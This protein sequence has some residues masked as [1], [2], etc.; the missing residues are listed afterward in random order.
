MNYD[1]INHSCQV[2]SDDKNGIVGE[3]ID[4][5]LK[6]VCE[7][8]IKAEITV[9]EFESVRI[10]GQVKDSCGCPM[11]RT[12]LKLLRCD[13]ENFSGIAHTISDCQGFYQFDLCKKTEGGKYRIIAG[14]VSECGEMCE[15]K[16]LA[17]PLFVQ[18]GKQV[19]D[20]RV[21]KSTDYTC[22]SGENC[23]W[24]ENGYVEDYHCQC[25]KCLLCKTCTYYD[26]ETEKCC[27]SR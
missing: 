17:H 8:E 14:R 7:S 20:M 11:P 21:C 1:E 26:E 24:G 6:D 2:C 23:E 3:S 18:H 15:R 10:W 25:K 4:I 22:L 9:K 13:C 5:V 19:C 27:F 12:L 16:T